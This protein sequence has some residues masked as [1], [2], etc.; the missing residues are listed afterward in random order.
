M[1]GA[2]SVAGAW[3]AGAW[4]AEAWVAEAW[5]AVRECSSA[6]ALVSGTVSAEARGPQRPE[7]RCWPRLPRGAP[8]IL[9][10]RGI[11]LLCCSAPLHSYHGLM[12]TQML[13]SVLRQRWGKESHGSPSAGVNG[14]VRM[15]PCD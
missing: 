1:L 12:S 10:L 3:V 13:T 14:T 6:A 11:A 4:V 5:A 2:R 8:P 7:P 9:A 15:Y